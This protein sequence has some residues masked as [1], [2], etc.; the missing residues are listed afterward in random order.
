MCNG[1]Q[2][3]AALR[4]DLEVRDV[5]G[6]ELP[7]HGVALAVRHASMELGVRAGPTRRSL[8]CRGRHGA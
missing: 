5:G 3:E 6:R 4:K 1:R 7:G 8:D 2:V